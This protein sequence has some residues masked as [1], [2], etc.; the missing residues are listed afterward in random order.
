MT[1]IELLKKRIESYKSQ[2]IELEDKL[3]QTFYEL[4]EELEKNGTVDSENDSWWFNAC[5][6]NG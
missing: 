6:A 4:D 5:E 3:E 2:I 1:R